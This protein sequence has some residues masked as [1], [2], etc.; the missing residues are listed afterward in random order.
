M[1]KRD[2]SPDGSPDSRFHGPDHARADEGGGRPLPKTAFSGNELH[3]QASR[4]ALEQASSPDVRAFAEHL[5]R[6]HEQAGMKTG[7]LA[8]REAGLTSGMEGSAGGM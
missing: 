4:Y 2:V 1:Q 8:E 7:Q 6:D 5:V 3:V